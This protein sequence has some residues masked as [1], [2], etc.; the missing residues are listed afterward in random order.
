VAVFLRRRDEALLAEIAQRSA[1]AL[2]P[3][4]LIGGPQ[5]GRSAPFSQRQHGSVEV[6]YAS[7]TRIFGELHGVGAHGEHASSSPSLAPLQRLADG[8][9]DAAVT[10]AH[11]REGVA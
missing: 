9:L 6:K 1:H 7:P 11:R 8:A 5:V 4:R 3:L 2:K 10:F